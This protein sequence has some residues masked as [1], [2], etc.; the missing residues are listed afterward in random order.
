MVRYPTFCTDET[1]YDL[2]TSKVIRKQY[3]KIAQG[4]LCRKAV[5]QLIQVGMWATTLSDALLLAFRIDENSLTEEEKQ[6]ANLC[7]KIA[8]T[9]YLARLFRRAAV[10][11]KFAANM[12]VLAE[13]KNL[14]NA[15]PVAQ[16]PVLNIGYYKNPNH[17]Q[18]NPNH[19]HPTDT[20]HTDPTRHKK[21][22]PLR[23]KAH[24]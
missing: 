20:N 18:T 6:A 11:E 23:L 10:D 22:I 5:A 8:Q 13:I 15:Q 3:R 24:T 12:K 21:P 19:N 14:I 9:E 7:F 4:R 17:N 1:P 16:L 2:I